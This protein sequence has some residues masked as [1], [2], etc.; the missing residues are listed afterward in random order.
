MN[1]G[2]FLSY[3]SDIEHSIENTGENNAVVHMVAQYKK[4]MKKY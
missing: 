1:K 3:H 4:K 2:D